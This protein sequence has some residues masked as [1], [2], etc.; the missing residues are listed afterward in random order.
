MVPNPSYRLRLV[1]GVLKGQNKNKKNM[2]KYLGGQRYEHQVPL[3]GHV[4]VGL[5]TGR[6]NVMRCCSC[7]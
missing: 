2:E 7:A 3:A 4:A 1:G 6:G 5:A